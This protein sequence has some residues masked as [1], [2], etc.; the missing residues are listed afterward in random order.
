MLSNVLSSGDINTLS[1]TKRLVWRWAR[2]S[3]EYRTEWLVL[4]KDMHKTLQRG[5]D[6]PRWLQQTR[7]VGRD[8]ITLEFQTD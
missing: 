2:N 5:R 7:H 8:D 6:N 3:R 1:G 4:C